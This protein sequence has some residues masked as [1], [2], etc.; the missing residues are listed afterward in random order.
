MKIPSQRRPPHCIHE[1]VTH[2]SMM[3]VTGSEHSAVT[4][5]AT[6]IIT[7]WSMFRRLFSTQNRP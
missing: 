1:S 6:T 5:H 7:V 4:P 2:S 3:S